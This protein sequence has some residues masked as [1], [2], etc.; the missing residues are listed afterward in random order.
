MRV[1][2]TQG[3]SG[4]LIDVVIVLVVLAAAGACLYL[5]FRR[6][7]IADRARQEAADD[8]EERPGTPPGEPGAP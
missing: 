7:S 3:R 5:L 8:T 4:S 1:S 6:G 2:T